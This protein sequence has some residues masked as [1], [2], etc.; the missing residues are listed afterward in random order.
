[1][2]AAG[3]RQHGGDGWSGAV[4]VLLAGRDRRRVTDAEAI[5]R[6][7]DELGQRHGGVGIV[8][9]SSTAHWRSPIV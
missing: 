8:V 5:A 6:L 7:A 9:V 1:M 4:L 2:T 3:A